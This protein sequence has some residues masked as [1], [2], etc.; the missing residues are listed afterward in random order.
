LISKIRNNEKEFA[1]Q[2]QFSKG[3]TE[4]YR[5]LN[6]LQAREQK[7]EDNFHE[8]GPKLSKKQPNF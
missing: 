5:G 3:I 1:G 6:S 2:D 7:N 8:N 4:F